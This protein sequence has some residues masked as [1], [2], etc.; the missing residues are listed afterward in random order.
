MRTANNWILTYTGRQFWPTD[1]RPEDVDIHDIAHALSLK[2]RF[3][4]HCRKF[5]SVAQHSVHASDLL[6]AK[7]QLAGLVHDM[8]EAYICDIAKPLRGDVPVIQ[9]IEDKLMAAIA[10]RYDFDPRVPARVHE[11][12]RI[13]C[14]SEM[15]DL[16][17][18]LDDDSP[19]F[20]GVRLLKHHIAPW[21]PKVAEC[22]FGERFNLLTG[23][24]HFHLS[25]V[26]GGVQ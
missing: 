5:Y 17:D 9:E 25:T 6:P 2:C 20:N 12:D 4:G 16:F 10:K 19:I 26:T 13:L 18:G 1:P 15:R 21:R 8:A 23:E 11:I 14:Y 7:F 24:T 22:A 3:T